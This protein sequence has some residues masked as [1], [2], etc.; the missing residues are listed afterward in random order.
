MSHSA[1]GV[2]EAGRGQIVIAVLSHV[3]DLDCSSCPQGLNPFL[4][5]PSYYVC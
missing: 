4:L 2:R 1:G 5:I 3:K